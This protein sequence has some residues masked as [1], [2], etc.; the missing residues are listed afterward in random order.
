ME[1]KQL[2]ALVAIAETGSFGEA[3]SRLCLTQSAISHQIGHLEEELGETLLIRG[4]PHVVPSASGRAVLASAYAVLAELSSI[5]SLFASADPGSLSGEII[6]AATSVGMTYLYGDLCEG[7][8]RRYPKVEVI[9]RSAD[10]AEEATRSVEKGAADVGFVPFIQE[11]PTLKRVP[12]GSTEDA[13]IVGK[14]HPL[15]KR[16][17]ISV[18]EMLQWPFVRFHRGSGSRSQSDLLFQA[19]GYPHI[20]TESNE[21]EFVKRVVSMG[22]ATAI[23]PVMAVAEEVRRAQLKALRIK[24]RPMRMEFGMVHVRSTRMRVVDALAHY[25]LEQRGQSLRFLSVDNIHLPFFK[26]A[27]LSQA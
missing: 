4:K 21:M 22:T 23:I 17:V 8:M 25:C 2:K 15:F 13:L 14:G 26:T 9:F 1:I 5:K 3:A 11:H 16:K 19:S 27:P 20:A 10:T 18:T 24:D 7:F 6:V 12:L